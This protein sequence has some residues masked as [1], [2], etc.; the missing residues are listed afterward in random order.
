MREF[1]GGPDII[2]DRTKI[3]DSDPYIV[4]EIHLPWAMSLDNFS[5]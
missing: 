4:R 3:S 5:L 2:E 1:E